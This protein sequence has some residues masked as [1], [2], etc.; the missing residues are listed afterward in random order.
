[1]NLISPS[2]R[3]GCFQVKYLHPLP[4]D[5]SVYR[6]LALILLV[7]ILLS[8]CT[9]GG[10]PTP[11]VVVPTST[12]VPTASPTQISTPLTI[13]VLPADMPQ[14]ES[15]QYQKIIYDLTQTNGMRFQVRNVLTPDDVALE[16]PALKI[17]IA[18]P[19][20]PGLATLAAAAP[21]VEFLAIGIPDLAPA[22]NL[23]SIGAGGLPVD[24]QAFLAGYIAGLVA[25]EWRVG[26]L[27]QKDTPGGDAA[28][29][30][31]SNGFHYYCGYCF[32]PDFPG[33]NSHN[34]YP[35]VVRIPTDAPL[36]DYHGYADL[37][38]HNIVNVVYLYPDIANADLASY[39]AQYGV[40]LISQTL[41]GEAVRPNWIASIQP[42]LISALKNIYPDL[43]AGKGGQVAPTPL[44]LT[45]VNQGLL[46]DAKMRLVQDVLTGLENGTIGTG[47]NP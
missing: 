4:G 7:F 15:D 14:A 18:L 38:I 42:D 13:L 11:A 16:E 6:K 45:D 22:S 2:C 28:V 12:S 46:S 5:I 25:P 17:V 27:S 30:A 24:Q 26:I 39:M 1:M 20:D 44:F 8:S 41:P 37:L 43:V 34:L 31:F 23:S 33:P 3:G 35:I 19:P 47:V 10:S 36:S 40:L 21:D 9:P 32:N 29:T